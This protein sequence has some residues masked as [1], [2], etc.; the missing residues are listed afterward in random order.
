MHVLH[1]INTI[2][3]LFRC[4]SSRDDNVP[5]WPFAGKKAPWSSAVL[6]EHGL[7]KAVV[8]QTSCRR[9]QGTVALS[10]DDFCD[11]S[12]PINKIKYVI[13][14]SQVSSRAQCH[15]M[16]TGTRKALHVGE[17]L[18]QRP[19]L[20]MHWSSDSIRDCC[21]IESALRAFTVSQHTCSYVYSIFN[22][23]RSINFKTVKML[24]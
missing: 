22:P 6:M 18:K 10:A 7:G 23:L 11:S 12:C 9:S 1:A 8:K 21:I 3:E 16:F 19:V 2:L 15:Q 20:L 5:L 4:A 13:I 17:L 14:Y 24:K